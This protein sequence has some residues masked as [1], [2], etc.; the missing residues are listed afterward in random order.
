M[1]NR[2][3][4]RVFGFGNLEARRGCHKPC[5]Y[6]VEPD[7]VGRE[8]LTRSIESVVAE[9]R[10]LREMGIRYVHFCDSEFNVGSQRFT[11]ELCETLIRENMDVRWS[12]FITPDIHTLSPEICRLMKQAGCDEVGLSVDSGSE[13]ILAGMGKHH[14]VDDAAEAGPGNRRKHW[15]RPSLS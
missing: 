15:Q 13:S 10:E 9:L 5:G 12:A 7:I 3:Y 11:R 14:T 1:R 6:C 2:D 8:V 4:Y